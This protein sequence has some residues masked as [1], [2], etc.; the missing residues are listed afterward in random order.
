MVTKL[1]SGGLYAALTNVTLPLVSGTGGGTGGVVSGASGDDRRNTHDAQHEAG[2]RLLLRIDSIM[3]ERGVV[4]GGT[5]DGGAVNA[6][7][8]N[9]IIA[10]QNSRPYFEDAHADFSISHSKNLAAV[11]YSAKKSGTVLLRTG[12]DIQHCREKRNYR[13]IIRRC[14][15]ESERRCVESA[16]SAGGATK[17]QRLFYELWTLKEAYVKMRGLSIFH[18]KD[19]PAFADAKGI[20]L[21]KD[22][23]DFA[24]Y[25]VRDAERESYILA[26]CREK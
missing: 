1:A 8:Q 10:E 9:K 22:E 19:A 7:A 26:L 23:A 18:I 14:Y 15:T 3:R 25:E 11:S 24:L 2:L 20:T 17:A 6:S 5:T 4:A 16:E 21:P 12:C 13:G